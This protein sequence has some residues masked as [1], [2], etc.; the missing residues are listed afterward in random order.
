MHFS[1]CVCVLY[2]SIHISAMLASVLHRVKLLL[3]VCVNGAALLA[4]KNNFLLREFYYYFSLLLL[5][6][7]RQLAPLINGRQDLDVHTH[8]DARDAMM[9]WFFALGRRGLGPDFC[10]TMWCPR[11]DT[12]ARLIRFKFFFR[13]DRR[14]YFYPILHVRH[15]LAMASES[16]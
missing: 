6:P 8:R 12:A 5:F 11:G 3:A 9:V 15:S 2:S 16:L 4:M 13:T 7:D 1:R 14:P 10:A